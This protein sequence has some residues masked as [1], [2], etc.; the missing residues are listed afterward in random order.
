MASEVTGIMGGTFD[1]VH[2]GHLAAAR[3]LRDVAVLGE[4][5]LMPNAMPP[6]RSAAPVAS[7][8]DRLRMVQL[9]VDRQPGLLPSALEVDRGGASYTI[10]T[11]RE[12]ARRF[13][14]RPFAILLGS[15]AALQIRSWHDADALL[16]EAH[17]VIFNRPETTLAPQTLHELGFAPARTQIVH[18]DTPAIA[19]HQVRDRLARG[20]SIDDLVPAAVADYIRTH[21]LY[22]A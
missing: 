9:A 10:D 11:V 1:P 8:D 18:L 13:P 2:N 20:A 12:L 21:D 6:H 7:A 3:Q 16:D 4:V 17:F 14:G 19:A 15:D 22:H 5:W